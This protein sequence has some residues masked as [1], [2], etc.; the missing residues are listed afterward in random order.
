MK[1]EQLT[2]IET[3]AI[4]E[5]RLDELSRN[6]TDSKAGIAEASACIR[7]T[8]DMATSAEDYWEIS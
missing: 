2:A 5:N 1:G 8:V 4:M 6:R 7:R 3:M